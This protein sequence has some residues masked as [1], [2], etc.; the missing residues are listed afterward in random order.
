MFLRSGEQCQLHQELRRVTTWQ[1]FLK[2]DQSIH[3][4]ERFCMILLGNIDPNLLVE[5]LNCISLFDPVEISR[6]QAAR[7]V[8]ESTGQAARGSVWKKMRSLIY[9]EIS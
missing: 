5:G 4:D 6:G 8:F 9:H 2:N 7:V 3:I 1:L